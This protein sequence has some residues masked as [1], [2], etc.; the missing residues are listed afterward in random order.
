MRKLITKSLIF[1]LIV[2][3][4]KAASTLFVEPVRVPEPRRFEAGRFDTVFIGSSRTMTAILT[5]EF[6]SMTGRACYNAGVTGGLPP[7]TFEWVEKILEQP[8]GVDTIFV[9][10]SG[11]STTPAEIYAALEFPGLIPET[12]WIE[13]PLYKS[14]MRYD[15]VV[16]DFFRPRLEG[17]PRL[18]EINL[19][20][21]ELDDA[22]RRNSSVESEA[23]GL[24]EPDDDYLEAIR[25]Q[26]SKAESK[27]VEI[28]FF[29]APRIR[30]KNELRV[31]GP[32]FR[33]IPEKNRLSVRHFDKALYSRS[34][35]A[36]NVH[37]NESGAKLFTT[38]LAESYLRKSSD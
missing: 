29:I 4:P 18:R 8:R 38:L 24:D 11:K 1:L 2:L 16:R 9:E 34:L 7:R 27:G 28:Y 35:S 12:S 13:F 37:L 25:N 20:D 15:K 30:S 23:A 17:T 3:A 6:D 31:V 36:D 14:T 32:V 10:L 19:L 26:I 5:E 22:W 33:N 21:T